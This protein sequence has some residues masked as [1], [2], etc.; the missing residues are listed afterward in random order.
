MPVKVSGE[1]I[2]FT[3]REA[4][5]EIYILACKR[6]GTTGPVTFSGLPQG[7]SEGDVLYEEPRTVQA[8]DGHFTDWFGPH[9][10]HVYR[11]KKS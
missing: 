10:V 5:N 9:E 3:V 8:K 2:E 11:F 4:G 1:G 6:E 7:V